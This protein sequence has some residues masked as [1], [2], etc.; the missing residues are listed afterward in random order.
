MN[1]GLLLPKNADVI[2]QAYAVDRKKVLSVI[3]NN[4]LMGGSLVIP[5]SILCKI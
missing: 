1:N 5:F 3:Q 4:L 2:Y